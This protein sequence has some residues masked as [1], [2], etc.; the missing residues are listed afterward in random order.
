MPARDA[1]VG[2][3][4]NQP[5]GGLRN[6]VGM[7]EARWSVLLNKT[8]TLTAINVGDQRELCPISSCFGGIPAIDDG[9]KADTR[10]YLHLVAYVRGCQCR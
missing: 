4:W 6:R 1:V 8:P 10:C 5:R 7:E 2:A 3:F 9:W